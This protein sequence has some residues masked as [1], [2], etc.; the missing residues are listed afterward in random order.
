[1]SLNAP[2]NELNKNKNYA[3]IRRMIHYIYYKPT[4]LLII[5]FLFIF[6]ELYF[7]K[8]LYYMFY[9]FIL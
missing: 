7:T 4:I 8:K 2:L 3:Y 9:F 1:M 5:C 6:S